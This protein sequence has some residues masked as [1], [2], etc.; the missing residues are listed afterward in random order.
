MMEFDQ[1][2]LHEY[3]RWFAELYEIAVSKDKRW[4]ID[5]SDP[6]SYADYW[7]DGDTPME[8]YLAELTQWENSLEREIVFKSKI[9]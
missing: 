7:Q 2:H 3:S 4:L 8:A 5:A 1:E 6:L 9:A